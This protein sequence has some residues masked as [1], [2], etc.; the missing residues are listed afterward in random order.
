MMAMF[1]ILIEYDESKNEKTI[2]EKIE[3]DTDQDTKSVKEKKDVSSN[4]G[5]NSEGEK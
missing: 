3:D 1:C 4:D 5:G 2:Q